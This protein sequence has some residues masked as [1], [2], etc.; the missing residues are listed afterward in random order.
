MRTMLIWACC[1]GL[2]A[3]CGDG[4]GAAPTA[5]KQ[6]EINLSDVGG[7][8]RLYCF[9]NKKAPTTFEELKLLQQ[10]NPLGFEAVKSGKVILLYGTPTPDPELEGTANSGSD[11]VLAYQAVVPQ[12]GGLVLMLDRSVKTMT[13]DEF[14]AA[15]KAGK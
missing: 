8:Y 11:Q 4:S 15:K 3:G 10:T 1:L 5:E 12:S 9:S 14:K 13:A 7:M 6:D 2:M